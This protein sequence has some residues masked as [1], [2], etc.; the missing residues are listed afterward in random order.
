MKLKTTYFVFAVLLI[1]MLI[2]LNILLYRQ[3]GT[4]Y[5]VVLSLSGIVSLFLVYFYRKVV[6]PVNT[7]TSGM[8]LLREQDFSSKLLPVGQADADKIVKMFNEMMGQLKNER[9]RLLEQNNFLNQLIEASPMGVILF[10]LEDKITMAN[11]ASLR[12]LNCLTFEDIKGK[13]INQLPSNLA[14][15]LDKIP[16]N[17]IRTIRLNDSEIYRC[18]RLS[19]LDRG[20]ARQFILIESLTAE[21][22]KAEKKAY[23]KV[24]RMIAHEVNNTIAGVTSTLTLVNESIDDKDLCDVVEVCASRCIN[25]SRFITNFANVAKIP[26]PKLLQTDINECVASC[27]IF[28][29]SMCRDKGVELN[30]ELCNQQIPVMLDAALFEQVMLNV[31]KNAVES[32][33][34]DGK[35]IIRTSR[36]P[37]LLEIIDNGRGIDA[38][39][40]QKLFSPFFSTKPTGQGI[41]LMIIREILI[42]HDFKF[43]LATHDDGTTRFKIF[44][45]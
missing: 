29:E 27:S 37:D 30:F 41:G 7:I 32:I 21:V 9:L 25:M 8:D 12:F 34:K 2:V 3:G 33:E 26:E 23:E 5:Y 42:K 28:L 45:K 6:R 40:E 17:E 22:F 44:F 14:K 4:Q 18:S 36:E 35:I 15:Q 38:E 13:A 16:Q 11:D 31:V 43:S 39:V 1:G 20:F 10:S 24:I 19:F